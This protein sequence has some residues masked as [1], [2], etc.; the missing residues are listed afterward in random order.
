VL[1]LGR[2]IFLPANTTVTAGIM[3]PIVAILPNEVEINIQI[4]TTTNNAI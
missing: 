4:I 3:D 2:D 1:D